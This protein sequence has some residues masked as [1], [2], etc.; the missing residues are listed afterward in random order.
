MAATEHC[1]A[2]IGG[3]TAGAEVA[4]RLA[5]LG[6]IVVVFEQNPRP[7]GKIEDGLPSWHAALRKKE[8]DSIQSKLTRPGVHYVPNTR[9][10][11]DI[12]IA[13]LATEWGFSAVV[14]A[15]GAWRDRPVPVEGADKYVGK[16][17]VYQNPFVISFNHQDDPGFSGERFD[18]PD[19]CIV[20]GG[21]L[22]SIDVAKI[23]MLENVKR[24][25]DERGIDT[26]IIELEVKGIPKILA[27]HDLAYEDLG[28]L[29]C[30]IFYRRR[31]KD[32]PLMK[33]PAGA[34]EARIE[35][36]Y[37][38]RERMFAK[39]SEKFRFNVEPLS[40]PDG[41]IIEDNRLIGLRFRRTKIEDGR[42][43][44]T[45][46]TYER[47]GVRVISS[48]GSIPEPI[49]GIPMKGELFDFSDWEVG[50]IDGFPTLFSVGNVVTGKGNIVASRKHA[51]QVSADAIEAFLGLAE[52]GRD[53]E[54]DLPNLATDAAR[55]TADRISTQL[56]TAPDPSTL[57]EILR[58]VAER[59]RE[60]GYT[61]YES[62]IE[63]LTAP[64]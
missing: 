37:K 2:L 18:F 16:G 9:I 50:R 17:L 28:L 45:D 32:M 63:S 13:D 62:W 20:V 25:L 27:N 3:A 5:D 19:G 4:G 61:D 57:A 8:C 52:D 49:E 10:G 1:V 41:L 55:E 34:D 7:Y 51:R 39:A 60:V 22:A 35:K 44:P 38:G 30:T 48:I 11:R 43:I 42:V 29:G 40:T 12:D 64:T 59:Q 33:I 23:L 54:A 24:A 46:E 6:C 26:S 58:R 36:V 56:G 21:G 47:R 53:A 31:V 14:L 15:N